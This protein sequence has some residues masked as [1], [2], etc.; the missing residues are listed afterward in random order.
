MS[1][2]VFARMTFSPRLIHKCERHRQVM[3][4]GYT[5]NI[6]TIQ[7]IVKCR[8]CNS[9]R[10]ELWL[11]PTCAWSLGPCCC[12]GSEGTFVNNSDRN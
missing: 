9:Q 3:K 8:D 5:Q 7:F 12:L 1:H 4:K 10:Q 2:L 11:L 6:K